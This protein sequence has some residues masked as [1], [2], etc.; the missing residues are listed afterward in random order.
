V[1]LVADSDAIGFRRPLGRLVGLLRASIGVDCPVKI[2]GLA[3]WRSVSDVAR[4]YQV[5]RVF[6]AGDAA[7][8]MPP[9]GGFGGDLTTANVPAGTSFPL[10]GGNLFSR[11]C[12]ETPRVAL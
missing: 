4:R 10:V 6:I 12:G 7:H 1:C 9:N 3:R 8:V 5:G 11:L 2:D